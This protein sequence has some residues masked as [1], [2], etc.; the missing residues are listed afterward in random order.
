MSDGAY[1]FFAR[2]QTTGSYGATGT[3][4]YFPPELEGSVLLD[5]G[6][7]TVRSSLGRHPGC[8][9]RYRAGA[10]DTREWCSASISCPQGPE[11]SPRYSLHLDVTTWARDGVGNGRATAWE[12]ASNTYARFHVSMV[13]TDGGSP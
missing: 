11:H 5:G 8:E 9:V 4:P 12:P 6:A 1:E 13:P 7:A 2:R 10:N 3:I